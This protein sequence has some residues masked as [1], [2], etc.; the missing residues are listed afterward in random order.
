LQ[1]LFKILCFGV[2]GSGA[3]GMELP[4]PD[5]L[6][7]FSNYLSRFY[8]T[9]SELENKLTMAL[10]K[11][12]SMDN[13]LHFYEHLSYFQNLVK[14]FV[15]GQKIELTSWEKEAPQ[16]F[17]GFDLE[18]GEAMQIFQENRVE[19]CQIASCA[20]PQQKLILNRL[21]TSFQMILKT[22]CEQSIPELQNSFPNKT[23]EDLY[24][25]VAQY[26][27]TELPEDQEVSNHLALLKLT[28]NQG[29]DQ[30]WRTFFRVPALDAS[31]LAESVTLFHNSVVIPKLLFDEALCESR[32][33][34]PDSGT[35]IRKELK[36][37]LQKTKKE[38]YQWAFETYKSWISIT[39]EPIDRSLLLELYKQGKKI[40]AISPDVEFE[41][42]FMKSFQKKVRTQSFSTV[43]KNSQHQK[44]LKIYIFS[45]SSLEQD[46]P[47]QY[48][49]WM[50]GGPGLGWGDDLEVNPF[51]SSN[52]YQETNIFPTVVPMIEA[53]LQNRPDV[54]VILMTFHP[55]EIYEISGIELM[56]QFETQI[57]EIR[58]QFPKAPLS[59]V[60]HSCGGYIAGLMAFHQP[61][62]CQEW[63]KQI[64]LVGSVNTLNFQN[65][66]LGSYFQ[67]DS[68]NFP[69]SGHIPSP[70]IKTC[71][72]HLVHGKEDSNIPLNESGSI[73][74]SYFQDCRLDLLPNS[75]HHPYRLYPSPEDSGSLSSFA[76]F[77]KV[78]FKNRV[79]DFKEFIQI[80]LLGL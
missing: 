8:Q 79:N 28:T 60:G 56:S 66:E 29:L 58:K 48:L 53:I 59:V 63:F 70:K 19:L 34:F 14:P 10:P 62:Q 37:Q 75:G 30:F 5:G 11:K 52:Q 6:D 23:P 13:L 49:L 55:E 38:F 1:D 43:W 69:M 31:S 15:E 54:G 41:K 44:E 65:R 71:P 76:K 73:P 40:D 74:L 17:L 61:K 77:Y 12:S 26:S 27:Q 18:M 64:F 45:S 50:H 2:M 7:G 32:K 22:Q 4:K 51:Q 78:D 47:K 36:D 42:E 46:L 35:L 25:I 57:T 3:L 72:I 39:Q 67:L 20:K 33:I 24:Q 9:I 80:L 16:F 68:I 21:M